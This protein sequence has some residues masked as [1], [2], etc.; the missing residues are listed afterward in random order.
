MAK[1]NNSDT[2]LVITK[3]SQKFVRTENFSMVHGQSKQGYQLFYE[4]MSWI[5]SLLNENFHTLL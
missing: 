4:I 5:K 3:T 2:A 1:I